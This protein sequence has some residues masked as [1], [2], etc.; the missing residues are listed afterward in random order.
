M[1]N[2]SC[3]SENGLKGETVPRVLFAMICSECKWEKKNT[4]EGIDLHSWTADCLLQ[5]AGDMLKMF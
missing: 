1:Q 3:L 5:R 2:T 4:S